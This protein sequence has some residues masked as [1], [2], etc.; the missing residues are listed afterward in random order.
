[1]RLHA[2][3]LP[4]LVRQGHFHSREPS[5][6]VIEVT[7]NTGSGAIYRKWQ[8]VHRLR[9][10]KKNISVV[11]VSAV[12][13]AGSDTQIAMRVVTAHGQILDFTEYHAV[14][15]QEEP[16]SL[17][18]RR[19]NHYSDPTMACVSCVNS[20]GS[21]LPRKDILA[22]KC[23][24]SVHS[25]LGVCGTPW[26]ECRSSSFRWKKGSHAPGTFLYL[27]SSNALTHNEIRKTVDCSEIHTT[28]SSRQ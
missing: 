21:S 2:R 27:T 4:L 10:R 8:N 14:S 18:H 1:M 17:F 13:S 23:K 22:C 16:T 3:S 19:V 9:H 15:I 12:E 6:P 28:C 26:I 7:V 20:S 24:K 5:C 25:H 11:T